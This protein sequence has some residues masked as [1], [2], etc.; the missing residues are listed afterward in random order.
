[1]SEV[2]NNEDYWLDKLNEY[3]RKVKNPDDLKKF[4]RRFEEDVKNDNYSPLDVLKTEVTVACTWWVAEESY[5]DMCRRE[6]LD[7]HDD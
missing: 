2:I 6:V 1:M 4:L 3:Y 7:E 5:I